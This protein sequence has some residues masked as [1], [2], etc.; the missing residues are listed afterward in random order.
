MRDKHMELNIRLHVGY[1]DDP[2]AVEAALRAA[3]EKAAVLEPLFAALESLGI[4]A[5]INGAF[6]EGRF[7]S[8]QAVRLDF[9]PSAV[10]M[11]FEN[12]V[13]PIRDDDGPT[14]QEVISAA[15]D[16]D[17]F[18]AATILFGAN[19]HIWEMSDSMFGSIA[20]LTHRYAIN[21]EES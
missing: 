19:D 7:D 16:E 11:H 21:S 9:G 18:I 6:L 15:S 1:D 20:R 2:E 3:I 5:E 4:E 14:A 8:S 12:D 17:L 13:R 10:R